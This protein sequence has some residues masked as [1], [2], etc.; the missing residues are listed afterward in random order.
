MVL[1]QDLHL[2]PF[3][4]QCISVT[5]GGLENVKRTINKKLEGFCLTFTF[6]QLSFKNLIKKNHGDG[7]LKKYEFYFVQKSTIQYKTVLSNVSTLSDVGFFKS[8]QF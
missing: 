7:K 1:T 5:L 4:K 3:C 8:D 2:K 6:L